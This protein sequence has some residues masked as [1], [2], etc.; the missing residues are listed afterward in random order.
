MVFYN[1]GELYLL[2]RATE[3]VAYWQENR[4]TALKNECEWIP[5]VVLQDISSLNMAIIYMQMNNIL[6]NIC[7]VLSKLV[8]G[9]FGVQNISLL[10]LFTE[11]MVTKSFLCSG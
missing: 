3:V 10:W 1:R 6:I 8:S 7:I 2:M 11:I 9:G 5:E 4:K